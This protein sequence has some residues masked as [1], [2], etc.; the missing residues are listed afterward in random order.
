V[1]IVY[2][3]CKKI[4]FG[5]Y[6]VNISTIQSQFSQQSLSSNQRIPNLYGHLLE[7]E[8]LR[9]AHAR[10]SQNSGANTPGCDG[11]TIKHF[12]KFLDSNLEQTITELSEG[13]FKPQPVR[14]VVIPKDNGSTRALGILTIR[15]RIVQEAIR[16]ILEPIFEPGF[17]SNSFGYRPSLSIHDAMS[18]VRQH[19]LHGCVWVLEGDIEACFDSLEHSTLL[20]FLRRRMDDERLLGLIE[21]FLLAGVMTDNQWQP[22]ERGSQQ[23]A[24]ISPLLANIYLHRLDHFLESGY[25]KESRAMGY[26]RYADDFVVMTQS[27]Q[28]ADIIRQAL[29]GF[30]SSSLDLNLS[31]SKTLLTH[32]KKSIRFL[33]FAG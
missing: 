20:G 3:A 17:S 26:V 29:R 2:F 13:T 4:Y 14:R 21:Q 7:P 24:I 18:A 12:N 15:D 22:T 23:G 5:R 25:L 30:L 16:M 32:L 19:A 27:K 1:Q 28:D 31:E 9:A 8:W 11:I 10:I 33:G 6:T